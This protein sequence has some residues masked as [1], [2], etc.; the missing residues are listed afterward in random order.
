MIAI[1][2]TQNLSRVFGRIHAV[3]DVSLT[4]NEGDLYGLL[5]QNGAGKTT[6]MRMILGLIRPS[7]GR[8][9]LFGK[10]APANFI[11]VMSQIGALVELP[12]Y[13][14]HLSAAANLEI[15]RLLTPGVAAARIP[16]IL[17]QVGLASRMHDAVRTFSQGM[18]QRL[19]IAMAIVHKPKL[20]ILDEPTN[21]LDPGGINHI[22]ELIQ[23]MNR[24]DGMTFII[25]SHL[26]HEIEIT[27][28]RVGII[29][30]GRVLV[31]DTVAGL[32]AKTANIVRIDAEPR[33]SLKELLSKIPWVSGVAEKPDGSFTAQADPA[34][35]AELNTELV[36]AGMA[37]RAFAPKQMSLEEYFL[38]H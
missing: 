2:K 30:E 22:R 19:G 29:K 38:T 35:H 25:S 17:E 9:E 31:E 23:E 33:A 24:K 3:R 14:P 21:G 27:C 4:V 1:L 13:Y 12:A 26:L 8:V 32:L 16:E 18:R 6:T 20:V 5:G 34:R 28:N 37:V 36:K 10:D 7:S 15:V 11:E